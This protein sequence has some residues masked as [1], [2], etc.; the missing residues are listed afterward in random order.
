MK[1]IV[2]IALISLLASCRSTRNIQSAISKKDTVAVTKKSSA[3]NDSIEFMNAALKQLE[4]NKITFNTF[5]AKINVDYRDAAD[6]KY[7]V[8]ATVRMANDSAIWI[9]VNAV[10]GIEAMRV[11]ITKDSVKLMDKLNK[12]YTAR[13]VDYL[14]EVSS[15]P[16]DLRTLQDLILGNPV[17]LSNNLIS[18]NK[19]SD[20]LSI[21]SVGQYFRHLLTLDEDD[22]KLQRSKLDDV[23]I[24]RN[25]TADLT[26]SEYQKKKDIR[27]ATKR[28]IT[29]VEKKKLDI[30]LDFKQY[31]FGEEVSFPFS[32]PKN[33]TR[34]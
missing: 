27:F 15:L 28:N 26:Y 24:K 29:V 6:K 12:K 7:D 8:N 22:K 10:L 16:L 17:F 2:F 32:V 33:Y 19:S 9:S 18:Y 5:T 14:Q 11:M 4:G 23:D 13:S 31:D 21:L 30:K 20:D 34:D 25:R 1:V 3:R